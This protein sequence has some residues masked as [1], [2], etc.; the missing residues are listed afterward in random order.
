M[1]YYEYIVEKFGDKLKLSSLSCNEITLEFIEKHIDKQWDW[2]I[3]WKHDWRNNLQYKETNDAS[4]IM[5]KFIE[6]N[7]DKL[8]EITTTEKCWGVTHVSVGTLIYKFDQNYFPSNNP[9][10]FEE[11]ASLDIIEKYF[12][13]NKCFRNILERYLQYNRNVTLEFVEKHIDKLCRS[14]VLYNSNINIPLEFIEK[15]IDK[16]DVNCILYNSNINTLEF[17]EKYIDKS[18]NW[19]LISSIPNLTSQ[20]I[21]KHIDKNWDITVLIQNSNITF[22]VIE[23]FIEKHIDK[24]NTEKMMYN[25]SPPKVDFVSNYIFF[26]N[27]N[28]KKKF[29]TEYKNIQSSNLVL[30]NNTEKFEEFKDDLW[31]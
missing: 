14:S 9:Y 13:R 10:W 24:L 15:H 16:V 31:N 17:I 8:I 28:L 11:I 23:K 30:I 7:I 21:E 18:W 3:I 20:F 2:E 29:N 6:N 22:N 4:L 19:K 1:N 27:D 5:S 12:I 25:S 26:H